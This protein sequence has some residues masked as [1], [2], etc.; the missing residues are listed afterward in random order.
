M[1]SPNSLEE[2]YEV[3]SLM[4]KLSVM[5]I[6]EETLTF[7]IKSRN[8]NFKTH[9]DKN[10]IFNEENI[11]K[12]AMDLLCYFDYHFWIDEDKRKEVDRIHQIKIQKAEAEKKLKY[13]TS[14]IFRKDENN[15][16]ENYLP[17]T[18]KENSS[19]NKIMNFLKNIF[20]LN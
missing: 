18:I 15:R 19:L 9:I 8:S 7:I 2:V 11:S 6:P 1:I 5:K 20:K 17:V 4:D 14:D 3:L 10:D 12:E 13:N 16:H